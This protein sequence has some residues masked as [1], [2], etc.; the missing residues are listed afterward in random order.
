M[1]RTHAFRSVP[2]LGNSRANAPCA[3]LEPPFSINEGCYHLD[4]ATRLPVLYVE[5]NSANFTL[6]AR[7][8]E[9]TGRY[10]VERAETAELALERLSSGPLPAVLLLDLDLPGLSGLDLAEQLRAD[11]RYDQLPIIV[12]TASV[13]HRER[14]RAIEAGADA[15]VEKPF[16]IAELRRIV[17]SVLSVPRDDGEDELDGDL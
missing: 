4:V 17:D 15:F 5:D 16:D 1:P 11:E 8:L 6:C 3:P 7:V 9:V 13:M 10:A 2:N 12:V 14:R